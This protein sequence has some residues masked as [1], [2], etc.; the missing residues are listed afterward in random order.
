R[1]C[2]R[3]ALCLCGVAGPGDD[4]A[5]PLLVQDPPQSELSHGDPLRDQGTQP[6]HRLQPACEVHPGESL[7]AVEGLTVAVEGA[8]VVL[9]EATS[10]AHLARQQATGQGNTSDD[11][12][13][14]LSRCRQDLLQRLVPEGVEDDLYGRHMGALNR[15]QGLVTGFH[16][17]PVGAHA[18]LL[19]HGIQVVEDVVAVDDGRG[20]AVQ[21][22]QVDG[23]HTQVAAGIVVPGAEVSGSVVGRIL[24]HPAAHLGGD[25]QVGVLCQEASDESFTAPVTVD[26]GRVDESDT[27]GNCCAQCLHGVALA[28]FPPGRADLPGA[29]ADGADPG[30]STAEC[31][32]VHGRRS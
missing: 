32:F 30:T 20:W 10:I 16:R 31:A 1:G 13:P 28:D 19:D 26:V 22:H 9:T 24:R 4:H 21:L 6:F 5:D 12:D 11:A 2:G 8:V 3:I 25:G 27:F 23:V 15:S 18:P 29:E 7:S 14:G 17:H